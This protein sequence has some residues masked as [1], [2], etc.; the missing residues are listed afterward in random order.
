MRT[1]FTI[2]LLTFM[3]KQGFG[4]L[5]KS[6]QTVSV[7]GI[8]MY[9]EVYG[10]GEPLFLL[11]GW[12]QS[13]QFW[14]AYIPELAK[15]FQV[16]A[17]DLRGHGR[18]SPLKPDFT[19]EKSSKDVLGLLEYLGFEKVK[20]I[21]LS[22]GGLTLL[23]LARKNPEKIESM[24]L[25]GVSHNYN[26]SDNSD[27]AD[28]FSFESLPESFV[29]QLRETHHHGEDQVKALFDQ[30]LDY[31]IHLSEEEVRG[32]DAKTFLIQGDSDEILGVEP[33]IELH[34]KLSNSE[35][36]IVPGTGHIAIT[37][38]NLNDFLL[39]SVKFFSKN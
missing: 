9:Y 23:E 13:S 32:I 21:G 29:K 12:T 28:S 34:K 18:T 37:G 33:A 24:V 11:H 31:Q 35:L 10:Q 17:I 3:T 39:Y 5:A 20:A 30:N 15:H 19:I 2:L 6:A 16:Y 38:P 14:S 25:I 7:N 22:F 1:F 36:W 26:G 27:A 4:Q 8:E